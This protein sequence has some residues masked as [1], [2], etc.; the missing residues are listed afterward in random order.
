MVL[1]FIYLSVFQKEMKEYVET[2][3]EHNGEYK[4]YEFRL[5]QF[6]LVGLKKETCIF[7]IFKTF[8]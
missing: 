3:L 4:E 5:N 1:V 6:E 2:Y 7:H 8:Q